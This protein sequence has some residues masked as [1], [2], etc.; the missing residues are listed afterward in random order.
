MLGLIKGIYFFL[1]EVQ[2]QF[3]VNTSEKRFYAR[4]PHME[5]YFT[6]WTLQDTYLASEDDSFGP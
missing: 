5:L 6:V 1:S 4:S 2:A 3:L